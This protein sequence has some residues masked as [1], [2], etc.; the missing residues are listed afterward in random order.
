LEPHV[1]VDILVAKTSFINRFDLGF[2]VKKWICK[3]LDYE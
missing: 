1:Y 2:H 3:G